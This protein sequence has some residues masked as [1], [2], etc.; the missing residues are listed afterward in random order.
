[1][2]NYFLKN[3][4]Q[5]P[6][7]KK[8]HISNDRVVLLLL[9]LL[10]I[11]VFSITA[12]ISIYEFNP[13]LDHNNKTIHPFLTERSREYYKLY[14]SDNRKHIINQRNIE[15]MGSIH[16]VDIVYKDIETEWG[17]M[18][19]EY[20]MLYMFKKHQY[21]ILRFNDHCALVIIYRD[22][23]EALDKKSHE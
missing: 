18:K 13:L 11:S 9:F 19:S 17:F 21:E 16:P 6:A 20:Q 7:Q 15:V 22:Y 5:I 10:I 8:F 12:I 14:Q 4:K 2:D 23:I 3:H 1:M